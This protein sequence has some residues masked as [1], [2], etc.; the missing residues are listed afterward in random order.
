MTN[1]VERRHHCV[2]IIGVERRGAPI[3]TLEGHALPD[4]TLLLDEECLE[5]DQNRPETSP[6]IYPE[7]NER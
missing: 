7:R 1:W 2:R 5:A 6:E 4:P 3:H